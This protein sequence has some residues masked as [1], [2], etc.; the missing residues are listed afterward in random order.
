MKKIFNLF[1]A[2]SLLFM[3]SCN[4]NADFPTD[5]FLTGTAVE[6]GAIIAVNTDTEGK[7]LGVPSSQE[8]DVATVSF[9]EVSLDLEVILMSG[10]KDVKGYEI[11]KSLNGGTESVVVAGTTLPLSASYNTATEFTDGLGVTESDLR[12]GDVISFR[13]KIIKNDGSS[14]YS[15][16]GT[17][18]VTV[19]CSSDLAKTYDVSLHY[20][21]ASSAI[22]AWYTFQDTFTV[23]GVGEYR[24]TRVGHWTIPDLGGTPGMTITDLCGAITIPEQNLVDL[25]SNIV[26]GSGS[27]DGD[28]GIITL[29]YTIC[30][31]GDCRVYTATYTPVD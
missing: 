24:S 15:F 26:L 19:S 3:Y 31:S 13:T 20:V 17:Y 9:A 8:F 25:Y 1:V 6:G 30:A 29:E 4:D 14:V 16:E 23:T 12:I 2:I 10:G 7:L 21:R 28:T 27:I 11:V 18:N 22:D 5:D